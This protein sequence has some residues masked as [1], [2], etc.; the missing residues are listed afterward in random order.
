MRSCRE[1]VEGSGY[2][3]SV[4]G[5]LCGEGAPLVDKELLESLSSKIVLLLEKAG[6]LER[7]LGPG[8]LVTQHD[9]RAVGGYCSRYCNL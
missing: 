2:R 1:A 9:S 6:G 4:F 5:A 8:Y 7:V 3:S